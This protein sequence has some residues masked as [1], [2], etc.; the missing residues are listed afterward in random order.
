MIGRVVLLTGPVEA[1]VL[2][3]VLRRHN[4]DLQVYP[5]KTAADLDAIDAAVLPE[6]RLIAFVTPVVVPARILNR[7]GFGAYNFHPGPPQY[8]G[9]VPSHFAIYDRV[10]SFGATVHLM[11]ERV[12]EGPIVACE[13]FPVP[14]N[15]TVQ[16]LE[17]LAFSQLARLFWNLASSLVTQREPL[18]QLPVHWGGRKSTHKLYAAMCDIPLDI[19]K[20]DLDRRLEAFG[21]G[22]FG[23]FPTINLHGRAF[24]YAA[25]ETEL[26][27]GKDDSI[28]QQPVRPAVRR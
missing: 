17:A 21:A 11:T 24:R 14:S 12:D 28:A 5:A 18:P 16:I 19:A 10:E 23:L 1:P 20:E 4:P 6:A 26:Q 7:L 9:W 25:P 15:A 2:A 8:P 22:H 13:H 27:H 3:A